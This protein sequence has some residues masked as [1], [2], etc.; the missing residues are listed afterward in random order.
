MDKL[1]KRLVKK[2]RRLYGAVYTLPNGSQVYLA[3]RKLGEIFRAGKKSISEAVREGVAAWAIDEE[4][5]RERRLEG[6]KV[7]GVLCKESDDLWLAPLDKFFDTKFSK[8]MNYESRGGALQRYLPLKEFKRK[9]S[10]ATP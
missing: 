5:L 7:V 2:G 9:T 10:V 4:T 1:P 6:I 8:V 3:Y